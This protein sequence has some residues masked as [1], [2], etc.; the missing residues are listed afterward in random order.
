M[1]KMKT[2]ILLQI[3]SL[4]FIS[5]L[6]AQF[7]K[8]WLLSGGGQVSYYEQITKI[9]SASG[10]INKFKGFQTSIGIRAEVGYFLA[11][12]TSLSYQFTYLYYDDN[13]IN[14]FNNFKLYRHGISI[15][16]YLPLN[17]DLY[18]Q[19]GAMP[20]IGKRVYKEPSTPMPDMNETVHGCIFEGGVTFLIQKNSL[21]GINLFKILDN[22]AETSYFND[23]AGVSISYRYIFSKK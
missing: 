8:Q 6:N 12:N 23:K 4:L 17:N 16:K 19:I 7:N 2:K 5:K 13:R 21:L 22:N 14:G 15:V 11:K 9:T 20:F 10:V 18:L 3:I 1:N